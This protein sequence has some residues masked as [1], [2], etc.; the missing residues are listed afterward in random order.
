M[1]LLEQL[2][3]STTLGI[4]DLP[5]F[6]GIVAVYAACRYV[7]T[8]AFLV[9][10]GHLLRVK[11][12]AK[13]VHRSFDLFHYIVSTTLGALALWNRPYG[14]CVFWAGHCQSPLLPTP[15][16]CIVTVLEKMYYLYFCAYYIVD[17]MFI[18]TIPNDTFAVTCHHIA[19]VAMIVFSV[20]LRVPVI[21]VVIML[22]HDVV[23][24]PLYIGK[25]SSY[26]GLL[27]MSES[28]LLIFAVLCTWFRMINLPLIIWYTA[29]NL[30]KITY[31]VTL[32]KV[33]VGL[34][35]V[36]MICHFWWFAKILKA[37]IGIF[38]TG[39]S[40]IRDNRSDGSD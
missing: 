20:L 21:G 4:E 13:F 24:V 33:T 23:D 30:P 6:G 18:H 29:L 25:V 1:A 3:Q 32:Y 8:N 37:V 7:L 9:R 40:E 16:A 15:G 22:L 27:A 38:T 11:R 34:E 5:V 28:A 19:T 14:H 12:H 26:L 31:R 39:T 35:V 36:L 17:F 10:L 2:E